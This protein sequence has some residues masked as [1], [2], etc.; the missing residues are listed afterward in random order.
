ML[1]PHTLKPIMASLM[2]S[3]GD[4]KALTTSPSSP[5]VRGV[6]VVQFAGHIGSDSIGFQGK[7]GFSGAGAP[8]IQFH[9]LLCE[10]LA[11]CLISSRS[12]GCEK[13]LQLNFQICACK[14]VRE[15]GGSKS[16][17]SSGCRRRKMRRAC[18]VY[19]RDVRVCEPSPRAPEDRPRMT[20]VSAV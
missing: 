15:G 1:S 20:T 17:T 5:I 7:P 16:G 10:A 14:C 11:I 19:P 12:V 4:R 6:L 3:P 8:R 13:N 9:G 2:Q 18:A